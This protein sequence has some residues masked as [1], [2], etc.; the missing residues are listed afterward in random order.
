MAVIKIPSNLDAHVIVP[1]VYQGAY[2]KAYEKGGLHVLGFRALVLAAEELQPIGYFQD[3]EVIKVPYDDTYKDLP[4]S[5]WLK[6]KLTASR[7]ASLV[8]A[9][10]SVLITCAMGWNRSGLITAM[11]L[12][13][14]YP[15]IPGEKI[16]QQI[17]LRRPNALGNEAFVD[18]FIHWADNRPKKEIP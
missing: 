2:P 4:K 8:K 15:T 7:L 17:Q 16:V 12:A 11:T 6:I 3:V 14:L 10:N 9:G 18:R 5:Q 1:G 13:E